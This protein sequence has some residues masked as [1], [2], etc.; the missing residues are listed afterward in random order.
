MRVVIIGSSGG[1]GAALTRAWAARDTVEH[2]YAISRSG[3]GPVGPKIEAL[4]ADILDEASLEASAARLA[5]AGA[6]GCVILAT[7][8]LSTEKVRPE[9]SYRQQNMG[10]FQHVFAI[11]TFGAALVAKHFLPVMPRQGRAIFAALSARVGS[12]SD[13]HLG[14]WHAYRASKAALNMLL[15]NYA[16]EQARRNPD[17]IVAGLHPGTVDTALSQPFQS[18]VPVGKLFSPD[19]S[20]DYLVKV[21]DQLR[22]QDSGQVYDWQGKVIPA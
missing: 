14:G 20:A 5:G 8:T 9:K 22:P 6:P 7:G 17:F 18:N 2:V 13:N 10:N 1:I 4:K 3:Q 16:I 12:L 15:R 11:N 19:Q 21:M